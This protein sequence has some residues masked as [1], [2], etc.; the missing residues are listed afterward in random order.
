MID[1]F[2]DFTL[3]LLKLKIAK[4]GNRCRNFMVR[5][6]RWK[7]AKMLKMILTFYADKIFPVITVKRHLF[8]K[9]LPAL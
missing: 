7:R 2:H 5:P 6:L 8:N 1:R 9:I 4:D 3:L